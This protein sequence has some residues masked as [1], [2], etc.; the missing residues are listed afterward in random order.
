MGNWI[1]AVETICQDSSRER[2]FHEWYEK[3]HLPDIME[4]PGVVRGSRYEIKN[5]VKGQGKFVALYEIE[6]DDIDQ[7]MAALQKNVAQKSKQGRM[8]E[9]GSIV[10][11]SLY[12]QITKPLINK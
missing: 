8:S 12:R 11:R 7:T 2:E 9:L 3:I 10:S 1:Y 6:T 4:T 5:P